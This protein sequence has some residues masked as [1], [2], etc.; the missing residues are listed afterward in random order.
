[1]QRKEC[2]H[3]ALN[4][5]LE[6]ECLREEW[7]VELHPQESRVLTFWDTFEWGVWFSGH[8]LYSCNDVY[9]LCSRD[10][11]CLGPVLCEEPARG[12]RRFW[13]DFETLSMRAKLEGML[14]LRGL[15]PLVEGTFRLRQCDVRNNVGKIVCRLEC[16]SV[17]AGKRGEDELQH[18]CQVMP[19]LGYEAESA[20]VVKFLT[21]RGARMSAVG[22]LE[23]LLQHANRVPQKYTL[24][25]VFGLKMD[26]P[27]RE[28]VGRIVR[29]ILEIAICNV[30]GILNDLDTE[31]LHDYR[32][33]LR[34]IR[35][36][37]S[38]VKDVYPAEGTQRIRKILGDL[39]RQ[40]NRLRDLDVYLLSRDE[41]FESLPPG[42]RPALNEMFEDFAAERE[43]EVRRTVSKLRESSSRRLLR[44]M[45]GYFSEETLHEPSPASDLPVGPLVFRRIYKRY[46]K[47]R[48]IA[49]GIGAET[50][51]EAVHQLR[52]EC[53]KL[54]YLMEFFSELIP[55]EEGAAMQMLLRRL[56]N[57]LGEFN[58]ASVQQQSLMNYW[59]KKRSG[60][61]VALGLGGLVSILYHQQQQTRGLIIKAMEKFCGGS[62]AAAFKHT[63]KLPASI[64][65]ADVQ[66]PVQP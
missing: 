37:L 34:K 12:V 6:P 26:T 38:L 62:M 11:G 9:Q 44:E 50:P 60:T 22:P 13:K 15:A 42:L 49:A 57:R 20:R 43:K 52:I 48:E 7:N 58:D 33:C 39:A 40:T 56:Q 10:E 59:E 36:V 14:G 2:V 8:V 17:S 1:M 24:R 61:E 55:K 51:D 31:F 32:I 3:L 66:R 4:D 5:D 21:Q 30:P 63:F 25:P 23:I 53:K 54:R 45:E 65:A 18:S 46:R 35:S 27:S 29:T 16:A 19:L 47:I 41:Y 64:H 28:A